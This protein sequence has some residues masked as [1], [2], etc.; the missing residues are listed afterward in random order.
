MRARTLTSR[1][2]TSIDELRRDRSTHGEGTRLAHGGGAS[3]KDALP[4]ERD[5]QM[6]T[7]IIG[8][9]LAIAFGLFACAAP[10]AEEERASSDPQQENAAGEQT[11]ETS[12]ELRI[13]GGLG[14]SCA[15]TCSGGNQTCCCDVGQKC[16]SGATYCVCKSATDTRLIGGIYAR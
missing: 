16:E 2:R 13:G 11:G 1:A 5:C 14:N 7:Q 9:C 8:S 6:K 10:S 4:F 3:A 15:L 12:S